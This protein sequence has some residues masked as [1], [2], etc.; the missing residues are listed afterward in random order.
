MVYTVPSLKLIVFVNHILNRECQLSWPQLFDDKSITKWCLINF[1]HWA[2]TAPLVLR[3][4]RL[5][6]FMKR[7]QNKCKNDSIKRTEKGRLR[8]EKT[9]CE[10]GANHLMTIC[11]TQYVSKNVL[12]TCPL[13][14]CACVLDFIFVINNL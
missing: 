14:S 11:S 12:K 9:F 8:Q 2:S 6:S 10:R 13:V 7:V 4:A 1:G 3:T 5:N